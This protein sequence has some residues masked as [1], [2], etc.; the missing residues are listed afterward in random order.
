MFTRILAL[1]SVSLVLTEITEGV[2]AV[3][4][5]RQFLSGHPG[6]IPVYI[7]AGDTPLEDIN[8]DLA[9]AF[10]SYARRNGRLTYRRS[11]GTKSGEPGG[12]EEIPDLSEGLNLEEDLKPEEDDNNI[13]ASQEPSGSHIQKIPRN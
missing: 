1:V 7:R 10:D 3:V 13:S 12:D 11:L 5:S 6:L 2:P 4:S 8:P 9:D